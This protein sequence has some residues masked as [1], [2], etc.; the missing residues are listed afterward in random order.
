MVSSVGWR[1]VHKKVI[2]SEEGEGN[3]TL[4]LNMFPDKK[5]EIPYKE[6]DFPLF[7]TKKRLFLEVSVITDERLSIIADRCYTTPTHDRENA[8]KYEFIS[9]G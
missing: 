6:E 4:F 1:A 8:Q 2:I 7:V 9:K 3:F 5:F